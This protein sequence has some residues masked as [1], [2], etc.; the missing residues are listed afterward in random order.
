MLEKRVSIVEWSIH[1]G[2]T[3]EQRVHDHLEFIGWLSRNIFVWT[4]YPLVVYLHS[5]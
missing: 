4:L 1:S 3:S 2:G 5:F